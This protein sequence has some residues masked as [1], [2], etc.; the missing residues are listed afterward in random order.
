MSPGPSIS[1]TAASSPTAG[2]PLLS[3]LPTGPD[4]SASLPSMSWASA[5]TI[6]PGTCPTAPPSPPAAPRFP[7]KKPSKW[8]ASAPGDID[9]C[10]IY[11]CFTIVPIITLEDY[12]FCAKGEGGAFVA[13]GRTGP[14]GSL[15]MNTGGGLLSESGMA[16]MQLLVEGVRQLRGECGD[17]QV[18]GAETALVSGQGGIMHTHATAVLR[19]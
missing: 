6:S 19:R 10:E 14:D 5:S 7:A 12:S 1:W 17:R 18:K 9:V 15:P 11:D 13:E 4:T 8:R 3:P 16:G 2:L